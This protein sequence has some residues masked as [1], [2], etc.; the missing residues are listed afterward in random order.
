MFTKKF[1]IATA[2]IVV[3]GIASAG[4]AWLVWPN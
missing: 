3:L 2:L 4:L 1:T